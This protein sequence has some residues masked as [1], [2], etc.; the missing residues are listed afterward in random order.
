MR[1]REKPSRIALVMRTFDTGN[2]FLDYPA[3]FWQLISAPWSNLDV[4]WGVIPMYMSLVLGELYESK[5]SH[6][7]A[8]Q[9]G[10]NLLWAGID[11]GRVSLMPVL[12]E[13]LKRWYT[14]REP[15]RWPH[16][17]N[18]LAPL[19]EPPHPLISTT[20][21]LTILLGIASVVHGVGKR[22]GKVGRFFRYG[23]FSCYVCIMLYPLQTQVV[24]WRMHGWDAVFTIVIFFV[25][26]WLLLSLIFQVFLKLK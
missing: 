13:V 22:K 17:L 8:V 1:S 5:P 7:N 4:A 26:V 20:T 9:G 24:P 10:A 6:K 23:R 15:E 14:F 18:C 2:P 12:N 25:P 16:I 3:I 11:W 19:L 21:L